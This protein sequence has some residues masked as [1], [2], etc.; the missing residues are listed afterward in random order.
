MMCL[1]MVLITLFKF[2]IRDDR[3]IWD[4]CLM[5]L[6]IDTEL[7]KYSRGHAETL[8]QRADLGQG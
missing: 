5:K 7:N 8:S 4:Y 3:M 2:A 6:T 1:P